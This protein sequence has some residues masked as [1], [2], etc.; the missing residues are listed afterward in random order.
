MYESADKV[1]SLVMTNGKLFR[2]IPGTFRQLNDT[3]AFEYRL[4][5]E[6]NSRERAS[7]RVDQVAS[8][9]EEV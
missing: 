9:T 4:K 1:N 2:V 6:Y 3:Y 7:V 8:I 5:G